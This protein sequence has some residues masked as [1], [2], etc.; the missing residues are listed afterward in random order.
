MNGEIEI[1]DGEKLSYTFEVVAGETYVDIGP[2][3][4]R[5]H[6]QVP[7]HDAYKNVARKPLPEEL[8]IPE[9]VNSVFENAFVY[10]SHFHRDG[11]VNIT[12]KPTFPQVPASVT[13]EEYI[14]SL[15]NGKKT[16][17]VWATRAGSQPKAQAA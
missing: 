13:L 8:R 16:H 6:L 11:S 12:D 3:K 17:G 1:Y 10:A 4:V 5:Y 14:W 15:N 2:D 9:T 7:D